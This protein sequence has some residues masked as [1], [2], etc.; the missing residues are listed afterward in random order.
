VKRADSRPTKS[1]KPSRT[2]RRSASQQ[3]STA[4]GRAKKHRTGYLFKRGGVYWLEYQ[5]NGKRIRQ[6]L[7][8]S[9]P[10]EANVKRTRIMTPF[11]VAT[12]EEVLQTVKNR[13][14]S[15]E[16]RHESLSPTR[17]SPITIADAWETFVESPNRPDSGP[18]TLRQYNFQYHRFSRWVSE[19]HAEIT[20]LRSVTRPIAEEYATDLNSSGLSANTFNKHI[21]L[22]TL[23][24]N[25]LKHRAG[26]QTN[27]WVDISRKQ[28]RHQSRRELTSEELAMIVQNATGELHTMFALGIYTGLRLGDCCTLRWSETDLKRG[29]I[30]R[31]PRKTE[32]GTAK[33]VL[34]PLHPDLAA[35]LHDVRRPRS[36]QARKSD[37]RQGVR[38]KSK[39]LTHDYVLPK[40]AAEYLKRSDTITGQ[41]QRHFKL[42]GIQVHKEGT[43]KKRVQK[44]GESY[45]S[46]GVRAVVEVGFHSLRHTF[47]SLCREANAPLAVVE[48]IVGHSNPAM[49]RHYTHVGDTTAGLA[50]AALPKLIDCDDEHPAE[51]RALREVLSKLPQ[52]T[53]AELQLILDEIQKL[54][55]R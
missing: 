25:V 1:T 23:V 51:S 3:Q 37:K 9:D 30:T 32:R 16:Q 5:I 18:T 4:P 28:E 38:Q 50:I 11:T 6:S 39:S 10:K 27:P 43:G 19:Y 55:I 7:G 35:V 24:C 29:I 54:T 33:P 34:I 2:T 42:C 46:V 26:I 17:N 13:I 8:T 12:E 53:A 41:I 49:T 52:F 21:R 31:V 36:R 47:V 44:T 14:E 20:E 22:L 45:Q 40:S 15:T 48:A